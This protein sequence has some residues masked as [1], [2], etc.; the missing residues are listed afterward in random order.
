MASSRYMQVGRRVISRSAADAESRDLRK[1]ELIIIAKIKE[2]CEIYLRNI[3]NFAA[4][5]LA[6]VRQTTGE[7]HSVSRIFHSF[8]TTRRRGA[9]TPTTGYTGSA[10]T[11]EFCKILRKSKLFAKFSQGFRKSF[12]WGVSIEKHTYFHVFAVFAAHATE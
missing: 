7:K 5:L 4:N 1:Q 10:N 12:F 6:K 9:F 11:D 2:K 8:C 3:V